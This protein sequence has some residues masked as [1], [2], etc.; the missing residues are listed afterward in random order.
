METLMALIAF[1]KGIYMCA[2]SYL[3]LSN[4]AI[5]KDNSWGLKAN[6]IVSFKEM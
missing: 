6:E 5:V 3:Y 2:A 4:Q 1:D